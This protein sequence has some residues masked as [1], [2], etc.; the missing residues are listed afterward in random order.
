MENQADKTWDTDNW[1]IMLMDQV[2]G[3]WNLIP[4]MENQMGKGLYRIMPDNG[5]AGECPK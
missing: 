5:T 2:L 1:V 3:F 4:I